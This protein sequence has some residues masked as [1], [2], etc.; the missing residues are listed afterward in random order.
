[1]V[2]V[3]E[4]NIE[5]FTFYFFSEC[6]SFFSSCFGHKLANVFILYFFFLML[7][8]SFVGF[9][10]FLCLYR[11]LAKYFLEESKKT[12][13]E[14]VVLESFERA[15]FPLVFGCFHAVLI[16][17]LAVQTLVLFLVE[18]GYLAVKVFALRSRTPRSKFKGGL[19]FVTSLLR[20]TFIVTF[21][22]FERYD[23]PV[24]INEVHLHLVWLYLGCWVVEFLRDS[25]GSLLEV[26]ETLKK[27]F[28]KRESKKRQKKRARK[29]RQKNAIISSRQ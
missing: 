9:F 28:H 16:D 11:R 21:F 17:D 23:Y 29:Q 12:N 18:L 27:H 26:V 14:A 13:M 15:V 25:I 20:L 7:V 3:Y 24:V 5:M 4:G 10:F 19:F 8:F 1:L 6:R 22:L 2:L